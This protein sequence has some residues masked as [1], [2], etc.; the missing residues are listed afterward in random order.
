MSNQIHR[1]VPASA[2][3][4]EIYTPSQIVEFLKCH[5]ERLGFTSKIGLTTNCSKPHKKAWLPQC[6]T[7]QNT[8]IHT[9]PFFICYLKKPGIEHTGI[10]LPGI[11]VRKYMIYPEVIIMLDQANGARVYKKLA[12]GRGAFDGA[13]RSGSCQAQRKTTVLTP[14]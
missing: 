6:S 7:K 9:H 11:Y 10:F 13:S 1:L 3:T 2:K 4:E 8:H 14:F 12:G 5:M